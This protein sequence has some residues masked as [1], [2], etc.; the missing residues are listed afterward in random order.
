MLY[1]LILL[2]VLTAYGALVGAA[3]VAIAERMGVVSALLVVAGA[4]LLL[5]L[6]IY[7]VA[8]LI[9]RSEEKRKREAAAAGG[10]RALMI[11]AALSVLPVVVRSR[12]LALLAAAGGL[13]YFLV[14][15]TGS[16]APK[17]GARP[18]PL[19]GDDFHGR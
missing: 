11:T 1:A 4:A 13:G 18:G 9:R 8:L 17:H 10:S 6:F 15:G 2:F 16:I 19:A 7:L 12:P 14:K 5:A 3:A